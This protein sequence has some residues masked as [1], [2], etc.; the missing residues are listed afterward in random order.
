MGFPGFGKGSDKAASP[1]DYLR[2]AEHGLRDAG[3]YLNPKKP[4]VSA[5]ITAYTLARSSLSLANYGLNP[6]DK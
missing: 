1:N 5:A 2:E 4:D 6:K 3:R